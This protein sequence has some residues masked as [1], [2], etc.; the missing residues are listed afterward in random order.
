MIHIS[1]MVFITMLHFAARTNSAASPGHENFGEKPDQYKTRLLKDTWL[2]VAL[3]SQPPQVS[4]TIRTPS[5][6]PAFT[7]PP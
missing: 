1:N 6:R 5:T 3:P 7:C 2:H 4:A